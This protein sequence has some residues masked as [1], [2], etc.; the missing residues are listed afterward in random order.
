MSFSKLKKIKN[1]FEKEQNEEDYII[2]KFKH[3]KCKIPLVV[4]KENYSRIGMGAYAQVYK[5]NV[6]K[7]NIAIRIVIW[8]KLLYNPEV[9]YKIYKMLYK[10][11]ERYNFIHIPVLFDSY[12]CD[13]LHTEDEIEN[14]LNKNY[15]FHKKDSKK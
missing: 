6:G 12:E 8:D 10:I 13:Y 7:I 3:N 1:L 14:R 15:K 9:E 2:T 11:F 5:I 4:D